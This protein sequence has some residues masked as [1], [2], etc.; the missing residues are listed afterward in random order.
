MRQAMKI[1]LPDPELSCMPFSSNEGSAYSHAMSAAAN[2]AWANRQMIAHQVQTAWQKVFGNS[3]GRLNILYD[4]A[5]NIAKIE[6]HNGLKLIVHRKGATRAFDKQPVLLPGSMG[7]ASYILA[8]IPGNS[9]FGSTS[10]GAGRRM[11]RHAALKAINAKELL[12]SLKSRG[13]F[14]QTD[15]LRG[16]AEEAPQ[17]YKD[18][19]E[20]V[21]VVQNAS[22]AKKVCCLRPLAIVKG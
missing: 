4:V 7:T 16:L 5:H 1:K 10:H 17:A 19:D 3:G 22:L 6:E 21:R 20:V 15:S 13:I 12:S 11:S 8:G 9:A 14:V 18:V 2:F